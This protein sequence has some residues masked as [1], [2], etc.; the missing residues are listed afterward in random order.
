MAVVKRVPG[1]LKTKKSAPPE[2]T[3]KFVLSTEITQPSD[4]LQDYIM[5]ISGEK[6]IG[7]TTLA[8]M[9]GKQAYFLAFEV[10]YRGLRLRKSDIPDWRTAKLA[11]RA[12]AKAGMKYGPIVVDTVDKAYDACERYVCEKLA[13]KNLADEEWGKGYAEA[14]REFDEWISGLTR[15]GNGLVFITHAELR[16]VKTRDGEKYD[17]VLPTMA[18]QARKVIEPL[19]DIWT[20]YTY[21]GKRRVLILEGDDHVSAGHRLMERFRTPS[22][23]ALRQVDMGRSPQEGFANLERAFNNQY[24]PEEGAPKKKRKTI[25]L[26]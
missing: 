21:D 3:E 22:G 14:K 15:I 18:K 13:I 16:E 6:K 4:R 1:K 24:D 8:N 26:A 17:R 20:Y 5:L 19:V 2:P 25:R 7:K 9:F 11:G 10:G 12:L 23:Q